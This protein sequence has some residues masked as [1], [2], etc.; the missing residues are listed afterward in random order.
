VDGLD[1][2]STGILAK[3][4]AEQADALLQGLVAHHPGVPDLGGDLVR[5]KRCRRGSSQ[6][7]K[8]V[9]GEA[10]ELDLHGVAEDSTSGQI[11]PEVVDEEDLS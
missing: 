3:S 2:L 5:R 6:G 11:E 1:V 10:T 9:E 4:P 8:E 7:S